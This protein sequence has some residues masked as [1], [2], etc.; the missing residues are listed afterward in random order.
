MSKSGNAMQINV[1]SFVSMLNKTY[2]KLIDSEPE[3][4]HFCIHVKLNISKTSNHTDIINID[5]D[6]CC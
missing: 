5:S 6:E 2:L 1:E 4:E 3:S